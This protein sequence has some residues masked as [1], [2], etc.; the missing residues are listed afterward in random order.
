MTTAI[1]MTGKLEP[2]SAWPAPGENCPIARTFETVGTRSA[3]V[4][5]REAFYGATRYEEFVERTGLSE[6]AVAT[7]LRELSDEGLLEKVPY[8]EPGQRVRSG[9]R[10]TEKGG[11]LLPVLVAMMR[12]GDRWLFPDGARVDL[13]HTGCGSRVDAVLQ[14]EEGHEVRLDELDLSQA[15]RRR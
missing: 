7:R 11:E 3:L 15:P 14:C 1:H 2:R 10:L 5:L 12:W 4:I 13:T 8:R 6:P 9:Y